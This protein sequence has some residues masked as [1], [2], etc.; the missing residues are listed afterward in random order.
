MYGSFKL[1]DGISVHSIVWLCIQQDSFSG[2][3][4]N[5][6]ITIPHFLHLSTE[7]Y[8]RFL[9]ADHEPDM[10]S[11]DGKIEYQLKPAPGTAVFDH[12]SD[13]KHGKLLTRH[14]RSVCILYSHLSSP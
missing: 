1:A 12:A 6:E 2:F 10:Q 7:G 5:I 11:E 4:K 3:Q 8:L 9:K 13:A 14:F